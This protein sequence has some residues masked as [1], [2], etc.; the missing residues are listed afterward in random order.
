MAYFTKEAYFQEETSD[1]TPEVPTTLKNK[2]AKVFYT[3]SKS[4]SKKIKEKEQK[5]TKEFDIKKPSEEDIDE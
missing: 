2:R 1:V 4:P 5:A 3:K